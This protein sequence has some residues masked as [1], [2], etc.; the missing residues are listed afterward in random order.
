MIRTL[1]TEPGPG[2]PTPPTPTPPTP[3]PPAPAP[4]APAPPAPAPVTPA[5]RPPPAARPACAHHPPR[6]RPPR[7]P[8]SSRDPRRRTAAPPPAPSPDK[9]PHPA[10]HGLNAVRSR[11]RLVLF[12][13]SAA[14]RARGRGVAEREL[15]PSWSPRRSCRSG[16]SGRAP[17][18]RWQGRSSPWRPR[19]P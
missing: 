3:A 18:G 19:G 6:L 15:R 12:P 10:P 13:S 4:P 8:P 17:S 16:R 9:K 14:G 11:V 7:P 2:V 5:P 1:D